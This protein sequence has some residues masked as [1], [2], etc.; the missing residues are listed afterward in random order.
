MA[1]SMSDPVRLNFNLKLKIAR[2]LF[3]GI[4]RYE[5]ESIQLPESSRESLRWSKLSTETRVDPAAKD[6]IQIFSVVD[7]LKGLS[8]QIIIGKDPW[9]CSCF[10]I[11]DF[12][13]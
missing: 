8:S 7:F 13:L 10:M 3:K 2:F 11:C 12:S 4:V 5:D 9:L 1:L 6:N